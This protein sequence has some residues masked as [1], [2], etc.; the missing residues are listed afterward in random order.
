M[1]NTAKPALYRRTRPSESE[2]RPNVTR[3]T[4]VATLK[5]SMTH[6]SRDVWL[7][8]SGFT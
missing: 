8:S 7:G 4:V 5:L 1:V 3:S 2:I 6:R